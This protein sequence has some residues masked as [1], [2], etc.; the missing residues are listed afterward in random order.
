MRKSVA[1][2]ILLASF[3]ACNAQSGI[4]VD[5][6]RKLKNA[7]TPSAGYGK[8]LG[9][10]TSGIYTITSAGLERQYTIDIPKN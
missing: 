10:F 1:I 4:S 9:D 5:V 7:P 8:D 2:F 3:F 6:A